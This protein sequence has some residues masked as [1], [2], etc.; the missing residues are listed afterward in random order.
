[1]SEVAG[2]TPRGTAIGAESIRHARIRKGSQVMFRRAQK[3]GVLAE[4]GIR[5]N[6][7]LIRRALQFGHDVGRDATSEEWIVGKRRR[8]PIDEHGALTGERGRHLPGS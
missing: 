6:R 4:I 5:S 3:S 1:M 2:K 7:L 8:L